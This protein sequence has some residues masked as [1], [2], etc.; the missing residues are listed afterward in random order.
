MGFKTVFVWC[1]CK[2][3]RSCL[4]ESQRSH[5][6]SIKA[7]WAPDQGDAIIIIII[8]II[9]IIIIIIMV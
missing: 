2:A 9:N 5:F 7:Y 6:H 4:L 1:I 8:L 3:Q